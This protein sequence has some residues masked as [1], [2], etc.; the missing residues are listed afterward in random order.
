MTRRVRLAALIIGPVAG[1]LLLALLPESYVSTDGS[2]V[3][4]SAAARATAAVGLWMAIWWMTEAISIYATALLPLAAF[5][6]LGAASIREAAAPYGHELIFLFLGGFV[7]ALALEHWGV[8]RRLA[9]RVLSVVGAR[10]ARMVGAFMLI[11][12]FISMWV[13]NTATTIMLLP[14]ALSVLALIPEEQGDSVQGRNLCLALLLGIAYAA[15]IGGVG[16]IIGTAPNVFVVSFIERQ[17]GVEISFLTWMSF[18]LPLVLVFLPLAWWLLVKWIFPLPPAPIEGVTDLLA[19]LRDELGAPGRGERLVFA[20]FLAT[21]AAW[22][23]RPLLN[24][25]EIGGSRPL[26]GLTDPGIAVISA[27]VLFV[28]PVRPSQGEF[29]MNWRTAVR[30]PWGLLILFG[31]G[32]SLAA[33]LDRSG[34]SAYLGGLASGLGSLPAP[35]I[36][37][38]V[39]SMMIFLTEITSN[40]ATTATLVPVLYAVALGLGLDP[41]VLIIPAAIAASCAFML[42]VATPPNAIVFGSGQVSL[43]QMSRAGLRLNLIGIILIPALVYALALPILG[44][45]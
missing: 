20:V 18:A 11:A 32:L 39:V 17:I 27:L 44:R 13:T 37:L 16:T 3:A 42:P 12:A 2:R 23:T 35:V 9:L 14:V 4:L 8:H 19:K 34:F 45:L 41:F 31:G 25:L 38:A 15:S 10:P 30:L 6:L 29:L 21:A 40:T 33:A 24:E 1:L 5:P 36:V 26:A 28:T 43:P 7:L 22:V